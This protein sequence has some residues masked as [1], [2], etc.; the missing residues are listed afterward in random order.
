MLYFT[1]A[2][3]PHMSTRRILTIGLELA[4]PD[5]QYA[6]FDSKMSLLD[7][8][9]VL[10]KPLISDYNGY[11]DFYQGKRSLS[12]SL[13]FLLKECCEH[14]RREIK[15]AVEAGKTVLVYL[16]ALDEVFVDT[17][18]RS[19][20]G[21]GRNRSTTRHV[22][23]YNNYQA[24]PVELTPVTATGSSMKLTVKGAEVLAPYWAEFENISTYH[25]ILT[26]TKVPACV[27][28]RTGDKAVG[29]IYRSKTSAGSLLLLPDIEFYADSFV[30]AKDKKRSW[31]PVASQFAGRMIAAIVALDKALR[32]AGEV[33]P[34]P[35]WAT[36]HKFSL[37]AESVLRA[38]LL[39]A[40]RD[41]ELAQRR[42][43]KLSDDLLAAGAYRGLLFE[44]GK[45]LEAAIIEAL[46]MFGFKAESFEEAD[47]EFDVVF[48]SG[49]GRLIGEA[50][51]KDSKP[52]NIDKLR[53]LSMNIHEDLQRD[54]V[55]TPAKAV[56][57]GNGFRL[58]P[59]QER[60]DPFTEKCQSAAATS[61]T[62]LV[63]TP[64]LFEPVRHLLATSDAAFAKA[65]RGAIL[66]STGRVSFPI[67]PAPEVHAEETRV[68]EAE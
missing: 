63:F 3:R 5:S 10:F 18:E 15:Q 17:G 60:G 21:T 44:K 12:D 56:L 36:D 38:D 48:E 39:E 55:S 65:C 50:E 49:E 22:A 9:I 8:D 13:S 29:A 54:T 23:S 32:T 20:S 59:P 31:T 46:R 68:S 14:W 19:Y 35:A 34:E 11:G 42:K 45:P 1:N 61:S 4:S 62:A 7:W 64:D 24:I 28:T 67:P 25:V 57:F 26:N 58:Q 52:I 6:R 51:G 33:T 37:P 53:Q 27:V 40:E 47:S 66:G 16:P 30:K 43:E 41:V 2:H